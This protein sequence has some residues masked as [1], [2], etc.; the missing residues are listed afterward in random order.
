MFGGTL[1]RRGCGGG[2]GRGVATVR[3][4]IAASRRTDTSQPFGVL[5]GLKLRLKIA[6]SY[7]R[8]PD[9]EGST[10]WCRVGGATI[11]PTRADEGSVSDEYVSLNC[12]VVSR[13]HANAVSEGARKPVVQDGTRGADIGAKL[14]DEPRLRSN[15]DTDSMQH[16]RCDDAFIERRRT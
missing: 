5:H 6:C 4:V 1:A 15:G 9:N 3:P 13:R 14:V 16:M 2:R 8:R 11:R 10:R 7:I 12:E